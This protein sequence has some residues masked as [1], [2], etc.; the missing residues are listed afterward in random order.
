[1][2]NYAIHGLES[3]KTDHQHFVINILNDQSNNTGQDLPNKQ[4]KTKLINKLHQFS[5]Q[6]ETTINTS[7][8][9]NELNFSSI[10]KLQFNFP[11]IPSP[12]PR[13]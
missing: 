8:N 12:P 10:F 2:G 13:S 9:K 11:K 1:M 6:N 7:I 3:H 5:Y 4:D